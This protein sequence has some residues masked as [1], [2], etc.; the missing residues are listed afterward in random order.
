MAT[1][2]PHTHT[3][4]IPTATTAEIETGTESGKAITPDQ[5][6]PVLDTLSGQAEGAVQDAQEAAAAAQEAAGT[7]ITY[8]VSS[9]DELAN[10]NLS[11]YDPAKLSL[12]VARWAGDT[13]LATAGYVAV[14]QP[15]NV[16]PTTDPMRVQDAS[17]MWFTF[18]EPVILPSHIGCAS[19]STVDDAA[20]L[21]LLADYARA[22]QK[23]LDINGWAGRIEST[24]D[25]RYVRLRG[26]YSRFY[27][28]GDNVGIIVGGYSGND[29]RK[30]RNPKQSLGYVQRVSGDTSYPSV[31]ARG[32]YKQVFDAQ[33]I[34]R[35]Q[36]YMDYD[37]VN[38]QDEACAYSEITLRSVNTFN[39]DNNPAGSS[40]IQWF[41]GNKVK[42]NSL[43]QSLNINAGTYI[44]N[45]N[46]FDVVVEGSAEIN[47][48]WC[49]DNFF[50]RVRFEG[51][52]VVNCGANA[53]Y[54]E[55]NPDWHDGSLPNGVS[56]RDRS[57]AV[58]LTLNQVTG[59]NRVIPKWAENRATTTILRASYQDVVLNNQ[60]RWPSR[61]PRLSTIQ[62]G[63]NG[64]ITKTKRFRA[65]GGD[66]FGFLRTGGAAGTY[67]VR[68]YFFDVNLAPITPANNVEFTSQTGQIVQVTGNYVSLA[69]AGGSGDIQVMHN[70]TVAWCEIELFGPP[71]SSNGTGQEIMVILRR[72][73]RTA[74]DRFRM[75]ATELAYAPNR[76]GDHPVTA[77]PTQGFVHNGYIANKSDGTALYQN[78][79]ELETTLS[80]AALSS[81]A[82]VTV[83]D[84]TGVAIGDV[85]GVQTDTLTTTTW[86]TVTGVAGNVVSFSGTMGTAAAIG[87]RVTFNRWVTVYLPAADT[88][89]SAMTGTGTKAAKA[90]YTTAAP[91]AYSAIT[92]TTPP[93]QIEM[94]AMSTALTA[95]SAS[96]IALL[97]DYKLLDGM[98]K[99]IR[100]TLAAKKFPNA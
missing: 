96:H 54:N 81:D 98:V 49:K 45:Q 87:Q 56:Y 85:M 23:V 41:N 100:T 32:M 55:F 22:T 59:T 21:N 69:A 40:P 92:L 88:G 24:V 65:S 95:L 44:H 4:Q 48:D 67:N 93:T 57:E 68:V 25:F 53:N 20:K 8:T 66:V 11:S 72:S 60:V 64:M 94:Q 33:F 30:T 62:A 63:A 42:I 7:I 52:P 47:L 50:K 10:I 1:I 5:L 2:P 12:Q 37:T 3:F 51:T 71:T 83:T 16:E 97:A 61:L 9:R 82:S 34:D 13:I 80:V 6:K 99:E 29:T 77:V 76:S 19:L 39:V 74:S 84:A 78:T 31:Q 86:K 73:Y 91:S 58:T 89:W 27:V 43:G 38:N 35:I 46:E 14:A 28:H 26:E 18:A 17:G 75:D 36:F 79:F 15:A 70:S 90:V